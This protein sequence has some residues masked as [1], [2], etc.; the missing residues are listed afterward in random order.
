ME[1]SS[2]ARPGRDAPPSK[3]R[4]NVPGNPYPIPTSRNETFDPAVRGTSPA[5]KSGLHRPGPIR[6]RRG[7][8]VQAT[9]G[10]STQRMLLGEDTDDDEEKDETMKPTKRL[11]SGRLRDDLV[12]LGTYDAGPDESV[13]GSASIDDY[14]LWTKPAAQ[15]IRSD[16]GITGS[17]DVWVGKQPLG[18]GGFGLAGLWEKI[19]AAGNVVD[20]RVLSWMVI[21]VADIERVSEWS[22]S[23][24][25]AGGTAVGILMSR[26]RSESWET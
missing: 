16:A 26:K 3:G 22:L 1:Q 21:I 18:E 14:R 17:P 10:S 5:A 2:G 25:V 11:Q 20:V 23:R 8:S 12:E 13:T 9:M 4:Q 24:S 7:V 19:D 6:R 15:F